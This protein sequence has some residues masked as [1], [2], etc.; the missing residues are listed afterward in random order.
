MKIYRCQIVS[1]AYTT[2]RPQGTE[3]SPV[4]ELCT[5]PDGYTYFSAADALPPQP[6]QIAAEEVELTAELRAQIKAESPHTRLIHRRMEAQIR[7]RYS[8]EDEQYFSRIGVGVALGAYVFQA[9]ELEELL[10]FGEFVEQVR[11]WGRVQRAEL[12]L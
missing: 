7:E 12:G 6:P 10:A 5:L 11:E 1:D 4:Q 3:E 9:G 2:Y 8:L